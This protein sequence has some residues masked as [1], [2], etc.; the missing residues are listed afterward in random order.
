M[1]G[2][3]RRGDGADK[4]IAA[5]RHR[6]DQPL[7]RAAVADRMTHCRDPA[8]QRRFGHDPAAPH[9]AQHIVAGHDAVPVLQEIKQDVEYLALERHAPAGARELAPLTIESIGP[10]PEDHPSL[11]RQG[12]R[13]GFRTFS[14][15]IKTISRSSAL[16]RAKLVRLPYRI[17][18]GDASAGGSNAQA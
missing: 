9:R 15:K 6:P 12:R 13:E 17:P 16:A 10:K 7:S 14:T 4:P 11:P 18:Q 1:A 8:A 3:P 2:R 5:A